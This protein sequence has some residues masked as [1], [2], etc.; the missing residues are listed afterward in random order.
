RDEEGVA[1][2]EEEDGIDDAE[3]EH[4]SHHLLNCDDE[5]ADGRQQLDEVQERPRRQRHAYDADSA[6]CPA[7]LL[8]GQLDRGVDGE[9]HCQRL[10]T[11]SIEHRTGNGF[12]ALAVDR[13]THSRR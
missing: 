8:V 10:L 3:V 7:T 5:V 12:L 11:A 6:H 4:L 9:Q 13:L 1:R 2:G